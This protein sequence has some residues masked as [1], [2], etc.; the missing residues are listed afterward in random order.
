MVDDNR[1]LPWPNLLGWVDRTLN[2]GIVLVQHDRLYP[3]YHGGEP[4]FVVR[5]ASADQLISSQG[6]SAFLHALRLHWVEA[7][8][9]HFEG[10]GHVRAVSI[11]PKFVHLADGTAFFAQAFTPLS[12]ANGD[13]KE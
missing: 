1:G 10:G 4:A 3:L 9:K 5:S 7:N 2:H 8:S 12:F 6:L 13:S 11:L